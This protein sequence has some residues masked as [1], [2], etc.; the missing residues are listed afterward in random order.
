MGA[1]D[2]GRVG[3]E[4]TRISPTVLKTVTLTKL[5]HLPLPPTRAHAPPSYISRILGRQLFF[6][7]FR[8]RMT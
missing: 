3:L 2:L 5:G 6:Q 4:P 8:H 7:F 1:K